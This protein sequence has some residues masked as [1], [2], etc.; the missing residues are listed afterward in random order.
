MAADVGMLLQIASRLV[1]VI[2]A[3][4]AGEDHTPVS[5]PCRTRVSKFRYA[6]GALGKYTYQVNRTR[7]FP[8]AVIQKH[9]GREKPLYETGNRQ[10]EPCKENS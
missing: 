5:S 8:A 9:T 10:I 2:R 1:R 6:I 7:R 3:S 4:L